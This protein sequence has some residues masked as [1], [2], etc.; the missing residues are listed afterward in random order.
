MNGSGIGDHVRALLPLNDELNTRKI[1]KE[2]DIEDFLCCCTPISIMGSDESVHDEILT[3]NLLFFI[4]LH[5]IMIVD[6]FHFKSLTPNRVCPLMV[7][8]LVH[9]M[10]Q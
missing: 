6:F 4:T 10:F 2:Q 9:A 5:F 3:H 7:S 1:N 8:K